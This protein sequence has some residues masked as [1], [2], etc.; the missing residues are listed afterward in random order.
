LESITF[1]TDDPS[2]WRWALTAEGYGPMIPEILGL[3]SLSVR[4]VDYRSLSDVVLESDER[5]LV[6]DIDN[7]FVAFLP[8]DERPPLL[9][10]GISTDHV[11]VGA[12]FNVQ[13]NGTSALGVVAENARRGTVVMLGDT[14]LATSFG[15]PNSLAAEVPDE[16]LDR[17]GRHEVYLHDGV[18]ESN[19]LTLSIIADD[20]H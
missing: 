7:D 20:G 2:F 6:F 14:P 17:P 4:V 12:R 5:N 18:R 15:S 3:P 1:V 16:I 11:E 10:Q 9:L 13:P 19:R 8:A